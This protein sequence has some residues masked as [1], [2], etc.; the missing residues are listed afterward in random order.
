MTPLSA[1]VTIEAPFYDMDMM[2]VAWHG[3]YLK[4]F[5]RARCALFD[6]M[7]YNYA[8]MEA[9]GYIWPIVDCRIKFVRPVR[10]GQQIDVS[11]TLVEYENR[12][13][14]NYR[15]SDHGSG[16]K[17]TTGYT[18][19]VALLLAT[20]EMCFVSPPILLEKIRCARC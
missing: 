9:S 11:A 18:I 6:R 8:Q 17:L 19:Q 3:H 12:M 16:E 15:I 5:E 1:T 13:K 7:D 14:L 10:F 4:Y 20:Q 2:R